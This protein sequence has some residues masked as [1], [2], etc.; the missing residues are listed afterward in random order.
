M[1]APSRRHAEGVIVYSRGSRRSRTPGSNVRRIPHA[2]GVL[3][4]RLRRATED[5]DHPFGMN[6]SRAITIRG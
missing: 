6:S 5:D 4:T 2:E 1:C 3:F